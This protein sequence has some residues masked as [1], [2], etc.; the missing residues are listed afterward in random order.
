M[1]TPRDNRW[2]DGRRTAP[3][4]VVWGE[5]NSRDRLDEVKKELGGGSLPVDRGTII[6]SVRAS[7]G[8]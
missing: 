5:M 1:A 6:G 7:T 4:F 2:E 8:G 3:F